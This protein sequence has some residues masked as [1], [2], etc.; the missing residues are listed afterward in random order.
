[1]SEMPDRL[2]HSPR[3]MLEISTEWQLCYFNAQRE[4][5]S[6]NPRGYWPILSALIKLCSVSRNQTLSES[7]QNILDHNVW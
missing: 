4:A 5:F 6:T 1:V 3:L 2:I 7:H